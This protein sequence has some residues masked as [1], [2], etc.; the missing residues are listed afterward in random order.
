[1]NIDVHHHWMPR[2]HIDNME[3]FMRKNERV[4]REGE[5]VHIFRD[6][7]EVFTIFPIYPDL[8]GQL[9][10]MDAARIDMAVLSTCL[11]QEW[12]T[13]K[14]APFI[15]DTLAEIQKKYPKKFIGLAHVPP[16]E[17]GAPKELE[18]AVK[19]LGLRGVC[20]NTHC[21]GKYPDDDAYRPLFQKAEE[22]DVPIVVHAAGAPAEYESL[23]KYGLHR[24]FGRAV[25][26]TLVVLK[27]L[28]SG[29]LK[30]YPRLKFVMGHIG[31]TWFALSERFLNAPPGHFSGINIRENLGQF[32]F[33][34]APAV[35][36]T[37]ELTCAAATIGADH[38]M[39]GTDFP[40]G[41]ADWMDKSVK[42]LE[43][44]KLSQADRKKIMSG[45]AMKLFKIAA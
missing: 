40:A 23:R 45:N 34:T 36:T 42:C 22:L 44:V 3:K 13:M 21:Q 18:R 25:D 15:N 14:M 31:G 27:L 2:E 1:M 10:A 38:L 7:I 19:V 37:A 8:Q 41:Q 28:F 30:D 12:N 29:I 33:D 9:K 24:L 39:L 26:H 20:I 16:F 17:K 32:Y 43:A 11:W 4:V 6:N 5:K 35:W